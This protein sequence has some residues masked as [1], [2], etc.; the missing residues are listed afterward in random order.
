MHTL[1]DYR[2]S[3]R[4]SLPARISAREWWRGSISQVTYGPRL[5]KETRCPSFCESEYL[6]RTVRD[7]NA[8]GLGM[9]ILTSGLLALIALIGAW[10]ALQQMLIAR[11]KL[12]IDLF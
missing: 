8:R 5:V 3:K 12:N 6:R 2:L 1:G 11:A 9:A 10:I 7:E 4:G